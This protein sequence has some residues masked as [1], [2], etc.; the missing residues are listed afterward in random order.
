[1]RRMKARGMV[2]CFPSA[3]QPLLSDM[4]GPCHINWRPH[5]RRTCIYAS[6]P[7][8]SNQP[9]QRPAHTSWGPSTIHSHSH[10]PHPPHPPPHTPHLEIQHRLGVWLWLGR[11]CALWPGQLVPGGRL[12]QL[13]LHGRGQGGCR[14]QRQ[15]AR[16]RCWELLAHLRRA[17]VGGW[18]WGDVTRNDGGVQIG[19]GRP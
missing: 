19:Q 3:G 7:C 18:G 14:R 10:T 5:A 12:R 13:L 6:M 15:L 1:M 16:R 17:Q 2:P 8:T 9:S 4:T 11:G